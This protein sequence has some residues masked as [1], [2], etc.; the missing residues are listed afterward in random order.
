[1]RN[2]YKILLTATLAFAFIFNAA[3]AEKTNWE[4]K[5]YNFKKAQKVIVYGFVNRDEK[6]FND[7]VMLEVLK[8]EYWKQAK[9]FKNYTLIE[10]V[11]TPEVG[12]PVEGAD[13]Y[14]VSDLLDWHDDQYTRPGYTSWETRR[15]T[16]KVRLP[17]GSSYDEEYTT[18]VPVH[19]P[20]YT[21]YTSTVRMRF[22]VF[23]AKTGKRVLAR[24][25]NRD[26]DD[27]KAQKGMFGRIVHSFFE[28]FNDKLSKE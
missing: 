19:H 10:G 25:D 8:E 2:I 9:N 17:D 13:L 23:D 27:K 7:D 11:G 14:I 24:D 26:R 28:D 3:N 21:V 22:S 1:M 4:D 20:P 16:R 5:T 18:S 15:N 6:E 12:K